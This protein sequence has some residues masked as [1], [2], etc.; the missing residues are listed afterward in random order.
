MVGT[1]GSELGAELGAGMV[2]SSVPGSPGTA[3]AE[4]GAHGVAPSPAELSALE[5]GAAGVTGVTGRAVLGWPA[6]GGSL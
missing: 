6:F 4:V 3:G 2:G 5:P 1:L